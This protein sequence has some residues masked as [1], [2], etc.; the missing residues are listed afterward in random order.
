[1]K[2]LKKLALKLDREDSLAAFKERFIIPNKK[3]LYL[4]GN[5]LGRLSIATRI[6]LVETIDDFWADRLIRGWGE[7]WYE[8]PSRIGNK[9]GKFLGARP[10]EVIISDSTTINLFKM[11]MAALLVNKE[12]KTIITD[13]LNFP[14]DLYV[15]Q[16]ATKILNQDH[17]LQLLRS[18]DQISISIDDYEKAPDEDTALVTFSTPTF[19][20]GFL[21]EIQLMTEMAHKVGALVLWDF[22]HAAGVVPIKLNEWGIDLAV[23]CTYKYLNGGPG[24]PAFLFIKKELQDTVLSQPWGWWGHKEPFAFD[25]KFNP[26]QSIRRFLVGTPPVLS[27]MAIEP[28]LDLV[29]EVGIESIR[30]KSVNLGEYFLELFE[31]YLVPLGFELGSPSKSNKRGSH[32]SIRHAEGYRISQALINEQDLIPDFREPD[33]IRLGFSPLYISF[34]DLYRSA[35]SIKEVVEQ[36]MYKKYSTERSTVR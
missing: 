13:E 26:A 34:I 14:T 8:A 12:R 22:S 3:L 30:K 21:H 24:S 17:H 7:N 2:D 5:S 9:L 20:S 15:I 18:E 27:M 16:G 11:V 19:K 1:M 28:A 4:D 35:L 32:I 23:G 31:E 29:I 10:G 36:E 25:L 33:N 6:A